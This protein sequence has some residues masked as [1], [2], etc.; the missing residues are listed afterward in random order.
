M[1]F[2]SSSNTLLSPQIVRKKQGMSGT[3]RARCL[4]NL[5]PSED[6]C[7][8]LNP[9]QMMTTG[10]KGVG[11]GSTGDGGCSERKKG[12]QTWKVPL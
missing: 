5:L 4:I 1:R 11:G 12:A 6:V 2:H 8:S 3:D 10:E 9:R 7:V